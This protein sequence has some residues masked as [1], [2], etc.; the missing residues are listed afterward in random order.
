MK[1]GEVRL[2]PFKRHKCNG[3][4]LSFRRIEELMQHNQLNHSDPNGYEC[5]ICK[6]FFDGMEQMRRHI[7]QIHPYRG[8][9]S[10]SNF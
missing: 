8:K 3:C 7:R 10:S 5:R 1:L 2:N 9:K 6:R 4:N